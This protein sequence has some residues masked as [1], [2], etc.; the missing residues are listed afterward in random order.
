MISAPMGCFSGS[1]RVGSVSVHAKT[2]SLSLKNESELCTCGAG[3][4]QWGSNSV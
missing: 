3:S 2:F 1:N 4:V